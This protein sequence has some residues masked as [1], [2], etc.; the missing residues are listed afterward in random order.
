MKYHSIDRFTIDWLINTLNQCMY[1]VIAYHIASDA[2]WLALRGGSETDGRHKSVAHF[3]R[4]RSED[5]IFRA[6]K[7]DS[8]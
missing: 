3:Y 1:F 8:N 4:D 2:Q 7:C 5:G 6:L